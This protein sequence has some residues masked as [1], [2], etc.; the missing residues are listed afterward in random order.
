MS[1]KRYS[2]LSIHLP[3]CKVLVAKQVLFLPF[4]LQIQTTKQWRRWAG[5][6]LLD[7]TGR[8]VPGHTWLSWY[9]G[10]VP[11]HRPATPEPDQQQPRSQHRSVHCIR[12][13][14][15]WRESESDIAS[16]WAH[17]KSNLM[18]T[19]S[20]DKDQRKKITFTFVVAQ[21]K[22]TLKRKL[23]YIKL[24]IAYEQISRIYVHWSHVVDTKNN[25][26]I[27]SQLSSF[28]QLL[29]KYS[30]N[31][32]IFIWSGEPVYDIPQPVPQPVVPPLP[33]R[34]R[35]NNLQSPSSNPCTPSGFEPN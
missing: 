17:R 1:H 20:S 3:S 26:R 8:L 34:T 35:F 19:W 25:W 4:L 7:D 22:W 11:E 30:H 5:E 14:L 21:C 12:V 27:S 9:R 23:P 6:S 16:K 29:H 2:N 18:F 10:S 13:H 24:T 32:I 15:Y 31:V 33:A 28:N